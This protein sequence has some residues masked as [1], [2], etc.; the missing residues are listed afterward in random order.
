[1]EIKMSYRCIYFAGTIAAMLSSSAF[2]VTGTATLNCTEQDAGGGKKEI[3]CALGTLKFIVPNTISLP[4]ASNGNQFDLTTSASGF[5][6]N[7][8]VSGVSGGSQ[9]IS[10]FTGNCTGASPPTVF[11]WGAIDSTAATAAALSIA[12]ATE[13]STTATLTLGSNVASLGIRLSACQ[14]AGVGCQSFDRSIVNTSLVVTPT[15]C[16]LTGVPTSSI[17]EGASISLGVTSCQNLQGLPTYSWRFNGALV[18]GNASTLSQHVPFPVGVAATSGVYT[19]TVCNPNGNATV[20]CM[21]VPNSNGVTVNKATTTGGELS[22]CPSGT[23]IDGSIDLGRESSRLFQSNTG[24]GDIP[25]VFKVIVP[26][27]TPAGEVSA[28]FTWNSSIGASTGKTLK[29]SR[30]QAC[31]TVGES[32]LGSVWSEGAKNVTYRSSGTPYFD[33]GSTWYV[34]VTSPGCTQNCNFNLEIFK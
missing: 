20:G 16:T 13:Q 27:P 2:A 26:N 25:V 6:C 19:L 30:N 28:R 4:S 18:G 10:T 24:S 12:N 17:S 32:T 31:G 1:M 14:S 21:T 3:T 5:T 33:A 22:L 7:P 9:Q 15:A 29:I 34:M 8:T 23:V 11:T